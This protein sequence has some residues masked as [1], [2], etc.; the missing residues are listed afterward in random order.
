MAF[1]FNV[2]EVDMYACIAANGEIAFLWL[3]AAVSP[4][5]LND[6]YGVENLDEIDTRIVRVHTVELLR[7]YILIRISS[8][9]HRCQGYLPICR[10]RFETSSLITLA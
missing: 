4:Q 3:G 6:L 10:H 8:R 9:R 7:V 1:C 2:H 5:I